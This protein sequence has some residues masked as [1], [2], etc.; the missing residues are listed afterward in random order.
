[1]RAQL[2]RRERAV[3]RA[4]ADARDVRPAAA[5]RPPSARGSSTADGRLDGAVAPAAPRGRGAAAAAPR[6]GSTASARWPCSAAATRCAGTTTARAIIRDASTRG[7]GRTVRVTLAARRTG[8]DVACRPS[9]EGRCEP[10]SDHQGLRGR[11]RRARDDRQEARGGRPA[12]RD[13]A[14]AVRARRP[15][16]A[17]LPRPARGGRAPHRDP[18]RA[19]PAQ[20]G[21]SRPRRRRRRR[22]RAADDRRDSGRRVPCEARARRGRGGARRRCC[23]RRPT[24]RR[25]SPR[26]CATACTAGGKRLRPILC[27]A[28]ADAVGGD[29]AARDA[30]R[31]RDRADSHLLA[32]PRRPAG[33][34]QRHAAPRPADAARRRRR[35][36]W[37]SWP[38]TGC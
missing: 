27:L 2:A 34:G 5:A 26:R 12:A 25:R 6:R 32:D 17:L 10:G 31:L 1:M 20:A 33:D 3:S 8:C 30:G 18:Q 23:P 11:D 22:R 36:A 21:A 19:R 16:V 13:V 15:A 35:R 4:A 14:A 7:A 37:R 29:R 24:A 28:S 9:T 38:A